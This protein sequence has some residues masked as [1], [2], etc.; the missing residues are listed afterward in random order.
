MSFLDL[1][2]QLITL[3]EAVELV[4][5][6]IADAKEFPPKVDVTLVEGAVANV[7]HLELA[8]H[9]RARSKIVV[10]FGDCAVT[11]NVTSLR[12]RLQV[13][14]LLTQVYREGPGKAPCGGEAD[15][16]MPALL[17]KVLPLHQVIEV[18]AFIP[19]CP[20]DPDRIWAA[21][22]A[23]LRG[24]PVALDASMRKFG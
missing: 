10:S 1:G 20:P 19:G 13:D 22:S 11:G 6:P 18:D 5:S 8:H 12:N 15:K 4:Y 9:I 17:P 2:E 23:L 3:A 16:V 24:E 14:D 7:D 21:V